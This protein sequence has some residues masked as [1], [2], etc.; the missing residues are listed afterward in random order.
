[1]PQALPGV[2]SSTPSISM[3]SR[4][5]GGLLRVVSPAQLDDEEQQRLSILSQV[6]RPQLP[7]DL[8]HY[9][10]SRWEMFRNH[11]N[12]GTNSLNERLLR[13]Q[14]MF[15]G[16]Y[17]PS[18][19][20]EIRRFGG[21]EVYSRLVAVKCRGA[22]SLL[23][24]VY[25]G[26]QMPW[27]ISAQPD[28]PIPEEIT[29]SVMRLVAQEQQA[30]QMQGT[31]VAPEE[32]HQRLFDMMYQAQQAAR[33]Q[34]MRQ[35]E[36]ATNRVEDT[37][38]AGHFYDALAEFLADLPQF[39]FACLK[40]PV[41]KMVPRL[42]WVQGKPQIEQIPQMFWVRVD[43]FNI[44]WTPG[45]SRFDQCEIIERQKLT[46]TD[47]NDLLDLPGYDQ[48]AVRGALQDYANG[49]RDWL[50]A[51]DSETAITAGRE[52]PNTNRSNMIDAIE[53]H[54]NVQGQLLMD[55]GVSKDLITD[56]DREFS[57]QTWVV[58]RHV[59]KTQLNPSPRQRHPYFLTS[60]E[61]V[62]GT[63]AGH[64]LPDILEDMQ[65]VANAALRSMVNNL[66]ISSGPQVVINDD[67]LSPTENADQLYP[68]KRWHVTDDPLGNNSKEPISFFQ[69]QSNSQE[70]LTIYRE[71]S[72][73]ADDIS[74]IPRYTTGESLSGGAGR[75][76]SGLSMLMN[77]AAKI[78][79]TVASNIDIDVMEP[80]LTQLYDMLMLTD[81]SGLLSGQ[82][83]IVVNGVNVAVQK[84][85]ERQKQIQFLQV[86]ANPIDAQ[87]LGVPGRAKVL[88]AIASNLGM[89]DD[90]VPDDQTIA[91]KEKEQ[92]QQKMALLAAQAGQLA[93]KAGGP[94]GSPGSPSGALAGSA[95]P[96]G[97]TP[98]GG[99]GQGEVPAPPVPGA[100]MAPDGQHY[101]PDTRPGRT[102]KYLRVVPQ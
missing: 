10:R 66:A 7:P 92:E 72:N 53:Y 15:E 19:I 86:T 6:N 87:I 100:R 55:Q 26:A 59:L 33:R 75:T 90:V 46:R 95:A 20:A 12:T 51:P 70:L 52:D 98:G 101:V 44:Y 99:G 45:A 74:A 64:G 1:M 94:S 5:G 56:P 58:G 80:C 93:Q 60:F 47:L 40:G 17:D 11:R 97:P 8:S 42:Q 67:R 3:A 31:P 68:W 50:D 36:E 88:R 61:K 102:G 85:T 54:G 84:E 21:S 14:R 4:P 23:R 62:A 28:P 37:L 65:E 89:P 24:D 43:P 30:A 41:V 32:A 77:N 71:I 48:A 2:S 91:H 69:P 63:V 49:L 9:V 35:A 57:V 83:E 39:P 78:L 73:I 29:M 81:D 96:S 79:Q 38:R 76:A 27:V 22:N 34:A 16:K 13:A 25:L 82:E 18:K